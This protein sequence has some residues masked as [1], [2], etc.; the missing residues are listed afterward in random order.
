MAITENSPNYL[1]LGGGYSLQELACRLP[2]SSFVITS[3]DAGRAEQFL[4]LGW[5]SFRLDDSAEGSLKA[6]FSRFPSISQVVDSV[7]PIAGS[8][9]TALIRRNAPIFQH[10]GVRRVVYLST[11]GVFG[12]RDGS[13]VDEHTA[14]QPWSPPG[15]ARLQCE[16]AYR[17]SG[18]PYT[19][20]RLPAIYG[21]GRGTE[22]S[23]RSG[24][25]RLVGEGTNWTNR[26]HVEDLAEIIRAALAA[27]ELP[28]VICVN[29]DEP[30]IAKEVVEFFCQ[31]FSL[32]FPPSVSEEELLKAGAFTL[33][34]NQRVS[35][36]LMKRVLGISLKYPNY[37]IF[38]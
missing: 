21:P 18:I 3:R 1:L 14:S 8:D 7:P 2:P 12:C 6:L 11:T 36:A 26:I 35:N 16:Q 5:Q 31:K 17:D 34:S 30:A 13:W 37:R 9:P 22:L 29:D 25:Y 38:A 23:I 28:P 15:I 24:R 32:P 27:S 4:G 10:A 20:L 19:A 33:L